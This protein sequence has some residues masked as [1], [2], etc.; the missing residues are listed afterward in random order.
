MKKDIL[1]ENY[2]KSNVIK[3]FLTLIK[4]NNLEVRI[5]NNK[6]V[7][8]YWN[9]GDLYNTAKFNYFQYEIPYYLNILFKTN[10][11]NGIIGLA[12]KFKHVENK[13]ILTQL[14]I[15]YNLIK[16]LLKPYKKVIQIFGTGFKFTL[17]KNDIFKNMVLIINCGFNIPHKLI[18]P[19]NININVI[20]NTT[21][22]LTS[23][24]KQQ[25]TSLGSLIKSIK[26]MNKYKLR[27]IKYE[28]EEFMKK[29]Y[30]K[31]K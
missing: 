28:N 19:S 20:D 18:I 22:E 6:L 4:K 23:I 25:L 7:V 26:P 2:L 8:Y 11:K 15:L 14:K 30:K 3:S 17:L 13:V 21:I 10:E 31:T 12:F 24:N 27:G 5:M 9:Q 16:G 1:Y 29:T